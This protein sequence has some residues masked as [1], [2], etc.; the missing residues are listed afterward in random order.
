MGRFL[1]LLEGQQPRPGQEDLR[2]FEWH[3]W[4]K[5]LQRGHISL[6]GHTGG[7]SSVA[8]SPDGQR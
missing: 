8:F 2:G 5:Q 7:V 4:M 1:D 6:L 3:Y